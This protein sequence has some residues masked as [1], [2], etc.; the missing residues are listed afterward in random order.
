M[1]KRTVDFVAPGEQQPEADHKMQKENSNT[2]NTSDEF[3]RD[4]RNEG[5]FSYSMA[6]NSEP[7]LS[8][9]VRYWGAERGGRKFDISIDDEKL[10]TEDNTRKWNQNKFQDVE[11]VIPDSMIKGKDRGQGKISGIARKYGWRGLL[12]SFGS[13]EI[14]VV[15]RKKNI[16]FFDKNMQFKGDLRLN[17]FTQRSPFYVC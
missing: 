6:T 2:G 10:V 11:Y 1:Q 17:L 15:N 5:Y 13:E 4:A 14:I 7:G 3:F 16:L 8:L 12:H 9:L